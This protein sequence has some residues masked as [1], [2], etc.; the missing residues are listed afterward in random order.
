MSILSIETAQWRAGSSVAL[1]AH[2]RKLRPLAPLPYSH[3]EKG[4][5][6]ESDQRTI[7]AR[8][9]GSDF[10]VEATETGKSDAQ[11]GAGTRERWDSRRGTIRH[12]LTLQAGQCRV[13]AWD[14]GLRAKA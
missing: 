3:T 6:P 9:R 1:S 2:S 13:N 14:R 11:G 12:A 5:L 10:G 8:E 4:L 7:A